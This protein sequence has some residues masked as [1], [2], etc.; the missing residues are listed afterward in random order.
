MAAERNVIYVNY[1]AWEE[2]TASTKLSIRYLY[3]H[4]QLSASAH[5]KAATYVWCSLL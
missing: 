5:G 1:V 2:E 3:I 4:R